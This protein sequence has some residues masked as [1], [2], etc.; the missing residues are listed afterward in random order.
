MLYI[1]IICLFII[2]FVKIIFF[3]PLSHLMEAQFACKEVL[4]PWGSLAG[5]SELWMRPGN[6]I[7]HSRNIPHASFQPLP[8][9]RPER[10][11]L[12]DFCH[13][14]LFLSVLLIQI[15]G[16][17]PYLFLYLASFELQHAGFWYSSTHACYCIT[18]WFLFVIE[19]CT[20]A[21]IYPQIVYSFSSFLKLYHEFM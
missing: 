4:R 8:T 1:T 7:C 12:P 14:K 13:Y 16:T 17:I 11:L 5:A 2:S 3:L 19:Q 21:W 18:D 10:Q 20:I 6:C 15:N 9:C